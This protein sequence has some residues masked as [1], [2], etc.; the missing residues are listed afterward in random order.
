MKILVTGGAGFIGS[1]VV[2]ALCAAGHTPV[3]V[4]DFSS[5]SE[6]NVRADVTYHRVAIADP[7]IKE[8]LRQEGIEAVCHIAAKTNLRDSLKDPM[9][10]LTTNIAGLVALLEACRELG[11]KKFVFSSTGGA[12]YGNAKSLPTT[13]ETPTNPVSPYGVSKLAG[14]RYLY[15][16]HKVHGMGVV[17]LRYSNVYGPRQERKNPPGALVLFINKLLAGEPITIFGDGEQTRDFVYV[18]DVAQANLSALMRTEPDY[19]V[20][21]ISSGVETSVNQL[22]AAARHAT[23]QE[24]RVAQGPA[25]AGE[26]RRSFLS[27]KKALSDLGWAPKVMLVEGMA[28]VVEYMRGNK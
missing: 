20:C 10:D 3:V 14:E 25:N 28:K 11:I 26:V 1:H 15:Y 16:Y 27:N 23:G 19:C 8:I 5:G 12:L 7:R 24:P 18:G 13:E 4:D 6:H 2:D 21:N 17:I 22:V 9:A